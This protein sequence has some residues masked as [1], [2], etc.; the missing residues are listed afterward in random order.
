M[1]GRGIE[2]DLELPSACFGV[3]GELKVGRF[4]AA[5]RPGLDRGDLHVDKMTAILV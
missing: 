4:D 2:E 1:A 3:E 5:Q